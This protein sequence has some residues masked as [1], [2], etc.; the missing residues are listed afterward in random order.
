MQSEK[1]IEQGGRSSG[2]SQS[3]VEKIKEESV[4]FQG[5][6][7]EVSKVIV[8][9]QDIVSFTALAILCDGH[10]LLEGVPGVAKTT[11]IKTVTNMVWLQ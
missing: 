6:N 5:L 2:V 9:Q 7:V 11:M 10:I 1:N 3:I 4:R 8:G